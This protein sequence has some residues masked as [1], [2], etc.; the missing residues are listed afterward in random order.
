MLPLPSLLPGPAYETRSR[1]RVRPQCRASRSGQIDAF[2]IA[3]TNCRNVHERTRAPD[4]CAATD[5]VQP[6]MQCIHPAPLLLAQRAKL[7]R[8]RHSQKYTNEL[9]LFARTNPSTRGQQAHPA[10]M[11]YRGS[12]DHGARLSKRARSRMQQMRGIARR[13]GMR[14]Q[15]VGIVG[16]GTMGGGIA[17]NLAQHGFA[18]LLTDARP[19]A[20]AEAVAAA[21]SFY[22]RAVGEGPADGTDASRGS[23]GSARRRPSRW[24]TSRAA[25]LVIEAVFEDFDLKAR[26]LA[27]LS[28]ILRADA[29]SRPTPAACGSA[30]SPAICARPERFLGLHYFSPAAVNPIVEVVEGA[31]TD[32]R[33]G[34]DGAGASAGASG[35]QP[36]RCRDSLRLCRQSLLLSLHQRGGARARCGA[37]QHR[38]DRRRGARCARGGRRA[39]RGDEPDQ[40]AHQSARHPQP[41]PRSGPFYAPAAAM[42]AAGEADRPFAIDAGRP[43]RAAERAAAIADHLLLGCFLPVLQALDEDVAEPAAFDQGARERAQVRHRSMRADGPPGRS[44]GRAHRRPGIG[45]VSA[46]RR[47]RRW[48]GSA[49]CTAND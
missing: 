21:G 20:A 3:Q 30:T 6:T 10:P 13:L 12:R 14:I 5:R 11:P 41:R 42:V 8:P 48:P 7:V 29:S 35:K 46:S 47:R 36:L 49:A 22:A 26:L 34:R 33:D 1:N 23:A 45:R 4:T 18:V 38:R 39:V 16:A 28:P 43:A 25:D 37:R 19:G 2:E 31:A 9:P 15:T 24:P 27:E 17:I 32:A 40:A 44:R